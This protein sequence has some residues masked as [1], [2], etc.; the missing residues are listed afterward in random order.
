MSIDATLHNRLVHSVR[1]ETPTVVSDQT[2]GFETQ[3]APLKTVFAEI[4]PA[5]Q[6]STSGGTHP[7]PLYAQYRLILR[8]DSAIALPL[9]AIWKNQV[10]HVTYIEDYQSYLVLHAEMEIAQ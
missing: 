4:T 9:R 5:G 7:S 6:A 10:L 8:A 3:W 1:L 2:G